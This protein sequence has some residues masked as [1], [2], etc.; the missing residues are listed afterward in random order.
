MY[1]YN[2]GSGVETETIVSSAKD[3]QTVPVGETYQLSK[4]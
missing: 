1:G 4:P 3:S 2:G